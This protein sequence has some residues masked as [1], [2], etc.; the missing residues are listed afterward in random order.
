MALNLEA[1]ISLDGS[2]FQRGMSNVVR[3]ATDGVR[4]LILSAVGVGALTEAFRA[5]VETANE[6][7]NTSRRL[8]IPVEQLQVL[9]QAAQNT[10]VEF[11]RV[12]ESM[13]KMN[14]AK[15][16]ALGRGTS[17]DSDQG[18]MRAFSRLGISNQQLRSSDSQQIFKA[19][20]DK[21]KQ[22]GNP[23][24]LIIPLREI[25]GRAGGRLIPLMEAD[26]DSL[27]K[28]MQE[29]GAIMSGETAAGLRELKNQSSEL[30]KIAQTTLAPAFLWLGMKAIELAKMFV[31]LIEF[32]NDK[33]GIGKVSRETGALVGQVGWK[34][35]FKL[36]ADQMSG[37]SNKD[38]DRKYGVDRKA[39]G[40]AIGQKD[41]FDS[42]ADVMQQAMADALAKISGAKV[43]VDNQPANTGAVQAGVTTIRRSISDSPL[44]RVGNFIGASGASLRQT[45]AIQAAVQTAQNT[46]RIAQNTA[47]LVTQSK[48][49]A[50]MDAATARLFQPMGWMNNDVHFPG[51]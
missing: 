20:A 49:K 41:P 39:L 43:S 45:A 14:E 10:G 11:D 36:M 19:I 6:L 1:T 42:W 4:N 32:L 34:N 37:M 25:F 50:G 44:A 26:L 35:F 38:L 23:Q 15:M 22:S 40:V 21:I 16:N 33:T 18:A 5:T 17:A 30:A 27:G 47:L 31:G 28:K 48:P 51:T 7:V 46:A 3:S 8:N 24:D 29:T 12:A 9:R 13:E 2:Q